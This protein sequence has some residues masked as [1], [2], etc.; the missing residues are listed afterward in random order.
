MRHKVGE[1]DGEKDR[2]G[3]IVEALIAPK[4]GKR[5]QASGGCC[6]ALCQKQD[7]V[8]DRVDDGDLKGI[9]DEG[10]VGEAGC[11][12]KVDALDRDDCVGVVVHVFHAALETSQAANA[13]PTHAFYERVLLP[14]P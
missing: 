9:L 5:N 1:H 7:K 12:A 4:N 2:D 6:Y 13:A 3:V 11:R 8:P 14:F 10:G